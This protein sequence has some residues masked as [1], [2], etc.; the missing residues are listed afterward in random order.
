MSDKAKSYRNTALIAISSV[1][2]ILFSVIKNKFLAVWLGPAGLG[3]FS[4]LNDF[5]SFVSSMTSMGVSNSGVQAISQA[6]TQSNSKVRT[7]YNSLIRFFTITSFTVVIAIIVFSK[8]ISLLLVH[9]ESLIWFIR[10]AAITVII[11]I[12]SLIQA[13]LI[14]GMQR[15]GLLAKANIYNGIIVTIISIIL[16]WFLREKSIPYLVITIALVSW[17]ISYT[18]T[19]KVLADLPTIKN[20]IANAELKPILVLGIATL[21]ASL[22]ENSVN[23]VAKSSITKQFHEDYLGYY[24]V[25]I[26]IIFQ[27]IGFITSSITSDYYPRLVATVSKGAD[28]V[29]KFVNQQIGISISL[30]MPLLLIMLTFSKPFIILL[31]SAKFLPSNDLISYSVAGTLLL[32]VCWPI[33]Y[34]FLAH[35]STKTYILSEFIGNSSHLTL[36]LIAV[37]LNNFPFL[38]LA[39]VLHYIIYLVLITYLFYK[40]FDGY[41]TKQNIKLFV[42]NIVLVFLIIIGKKLVSENIAYIFGSILILLYFYLSRKEYIYMFNSIVKKR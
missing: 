39:Y 6:S 38:G 19:R 5:I 35:R 42:V 1:I 21:W 2:N 15:V 18:Q 9:N 27:Y 40:R 20:R 3:K 14:T 12:R 8:Q 26:G 25:S 11:K 23:L 10:I 7:V 34:V 36:I 28:E 24:Q 16:V 31:F 37:W 41:I 17:A 29:A 4:I 13:T 30:I 22:L 33:A 32:V